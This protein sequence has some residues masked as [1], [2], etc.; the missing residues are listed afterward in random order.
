MRRPGGANHT[1]VSHA[2]YERTIAI[3]QETGSFEE[4]AKRLTD[5][6]YY[7]TRGAVHWRL[8]YAGLVD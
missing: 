7:I 3:Y 8:K 5:E 6:G 4:T 1:T 2:E